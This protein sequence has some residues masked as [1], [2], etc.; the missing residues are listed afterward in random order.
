M[1]YREFRAGTVDEADDGKLILRAAPF[2]SV[3]T[4]GDKSRGGWDEEIAPGCFA[5]ALREGDTVLL[6]D[7]D[8]AKPVSRVSAGTLRLAEGK[9]HLEGD[10]DP[11]DTTYVR[12]LLANI[13]AGNKGGMSIGFI[14]VKDEWFDDEGKPSNRMVGTR[15]VLREV[16]LPEVSIVTNPAYKDTAV[17]ARDD[18]AAL[19]EER[20]ANVAP[21]KTVTGT[22]YTDMA[23]GLITAYNEL[24]PEAKSELPEAL[25]SAFE[26]LEERS[27]TPEPDTSTRDDDDDEDFALRAAFREAEE[28]SR[29]LGAV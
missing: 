12:D 20:A 21:E 5:K 13:N 25:R 24:P 27:D 3:T 7:H 29:K 28:R 26:A 18:S 16:K 6:A 15:R 11:V 4:I 14:P 1:E 17:F 8:M 9:T 23:A 19:L 10:A 22:D 2:N